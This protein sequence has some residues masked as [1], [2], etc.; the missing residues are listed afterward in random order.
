MGKIRGLYCGTYSVIF[1]PACIVSLPL[2]CIF[3]PP[4]TSVHLTR[5]RSPGC[6]AHT[7]L[8]RGQEILVW[9]EGT[10]ERGGREEKAKGGDG[11][12]LGSPR[13]P[14]CAAAL[15]L[16]TL[17]WPISRGCGLS[18]LRGRP[19]RGFKFEDVPQR[20]LE[21]LINNDVVQSGLF[22]RCTVCLC[23]GSRH[24]RQQ[25]RSRRGIR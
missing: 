9:F 16:P 17:R 18:V 3:K 15:S 1:R 10:G 6:P 25:D 5:E 24:W 14:I 20:G 19:G 13:C 2:A 22:R 21:A 7:P 8:T 4:D 11:G 23:R 12:D